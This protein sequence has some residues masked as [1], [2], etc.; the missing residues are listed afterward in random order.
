MECEIQSPGM[1]FEREI[2]YICRRPQAGENYA[3]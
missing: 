2:G 3:N 1:E